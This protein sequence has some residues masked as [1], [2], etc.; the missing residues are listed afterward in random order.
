M[1][2]A[3]IGKYCWCRLQTS[4]SEARVW[5]QHWDWLSRSWHT[6]TAEVLVFA[7]S[8]GKLLLDS[9]GLASETPDLGE[10]LELENWDSSLT[11]ASWCNSGLWRHRSTN[12]R[13]SRDPAANQSTETGIT[14]CNGRTTKTIY[15]ASRRAAAAPPCRYEISPPHNCFWL[16]HVATPGTSN[17]RDYAVSTLASPLFLPSVSTYTSFISMWPVAFGEIISITAIT[18]VFMVSIMLK[19]GWGVLKW[20]K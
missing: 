7:Q 1:C 19:L 5:I 4:C 15:V 3:I 9:T 16:R 13:R 17:A 18:S 2:Y 10:L 14:L 20:W 6:G 12:Q 8:R 11:Q